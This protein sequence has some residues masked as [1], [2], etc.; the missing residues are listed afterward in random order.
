MVTQ[1]PPQSTPVCP[2]FRPP[3]LLLARSS[4]ATCPAHAAAPRPLLLQLP[5]V[6]LA[7]P[8]S[9]L[10]DPRYPAG[11]GA[12]SVGELTVGGNGELRANSESSGAGRRGREGGAPR[13]D[14]GEGGPGYY[15]GGAPRRRP[16]WGTP[17]ASSSLCGELPPR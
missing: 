10:P 1:P 4:P 6:S 13:D 16:W 2:P 11:G 9:A 8:P 17:P 5:Y 15:G 3:M 7:L 12:G 14:H